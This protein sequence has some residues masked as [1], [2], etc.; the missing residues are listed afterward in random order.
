MVQEVAA[1]ALYRRGRTAMQ[2]IS[3]NQMIEISAV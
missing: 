2:T 3:S 1:Q